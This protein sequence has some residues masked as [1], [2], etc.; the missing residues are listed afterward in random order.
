MGTAIR[1]LAIGCL[2]FVL[3]GCAPS[4]TPPTTSL[5]FP[6][7]TATARPT[8][9]APTPSPTLPPPPPLGLVRLWR[10][11]TQ[12]TVWTLG[13]ADVE[14]DGS[15]EV[16]AAS[17]DHEFYLFSGD[18]TVR[19]TFRAAAPLY[20]AV[21]ADANRDGRPEFFL[22][23]D[24]NRVYALDAD[25]NLLGTYAA[26]GRVTHLAVAD[27]D[28]DRADELIAASWDGV[29]A[30][31]D[32]SATLRS[33]IA[34][35]G[36]PSALITVDLDA[37]GAAELLYGTEEG[38][39]QAL[40]GNGTLVWEH[41]LEGPLRGILY[42][43]RPATGGTLWA[44]SREGLVAAIAVDGAPRWAQRFEGPLVSMAYWPG[45]DGDLLLVGRAGAIL[46]L[47]A[48]RGAVRWELPTDSAV[49]SFSVLDQPDGAVLVAG[50]D[51]GDL[52]L[53]NRWGQLR[54]SLRLPS[55]I[56]GLLPV[57]LDGDGSPEIVARS[58]DFV[59]AF[60]TAPEGDEDEPAPAVPTL[61]RWPEP[62]PL[63][64]LPEGRIS[65][66]AVGDLMLSRSI[67]ERMRGYGPDYPFRAIAPLVQQA[68]IAVGNLECVLSQRGDPLEKGY[69]FRGHPEL[70]AGL[71]T[72]GFDLVSLANN[73]AFDY[74]TE[75][76]QETVAALQRQGIRPVGGGVQAAS[77]VVV[78]VRGIRVAFLARNA[79]GVP[80]PGIAWA[81]SEE[82]I[83]TAVREARQRADLVVVLL[84]AGAEYAPE[85][86]EEQMRL[87]RAAVLAGADLVVG[88]HTHVT[89]P[90]ERFADGFIAYGLGDTVF[91]IDIVDAARDGA[92]LWVVLT[93]EGV[94]QAIWIPTRIVHDVQPRPL[95][96]ADGAPVWR[97]LFAEVSEPLPPPP[98]P[99]PH[100][101]FHV[102][103]DPE[104]ATVKVAQEVAF[105]NS[106]GL[107]LEEIPLQVFPNV[108][109]G[110]FSLDSVEGE[111]GGR[112]FAP[113]YTLNDAWLRL[114]LPYPVRPGDTLTL[115]L[116]YR[117]APPLLDPLAWPP[118]GNLGHT[119]DGRIF[120]LGHW[121]PQ[122]VPFV[123]D[124]GW[125]V[126]EYH[127]VGDP[128]V[129]DLAD[130]SV[131]VTV[132]ADYRVV[133][134][135]TRW[136]ESGVWR[137]ELAAA[138]D[139]ALLIAR[140]YFELS[141]RVDGVEVVSACRQEHASACQGVLEEAKRG[142]ALF[143]ERYGPYPYSTFVVVEGEMNGGMEY[144]AM[145]LVGSPFYEG[146]DGSAQ[147]I[148]PS[149]VV[150]EL[151]H[152]WWYGVVGND[153]VYEPWLDEALARYSELVYYEAI[154]PDAVSW[155]WQNRVDQWAPAGPVDATIYDY[156]DT[157]T[158]V[159]NV[160][161]RAAHWIQDLRDR[162]GDS[163]FFAF[164]QS[165]YRH[166]AW[167]RVTRTDFF[168]LLYQES[169]RPVDDLVRA[170]FLR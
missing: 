138:R 19:W 137:F 23:G 143:R 160:Y 104:A 92:A 95:A 80:Q 15:L 150:H 83:A 27:V 43:P 165:Y 161:G 64:P 10:A 87:A 82:E 55:R 115:T 94:A 73:H 146:Y 154:Y 113:S 25:G 157:R 49:W 3:A 2:W 125:M 62:S 42:A 7:A 119:Q 53:V 47:D 65:L 67:E 51:G 31:L 18:G 58:G 30:I 8:G 48:E 16:W 59:Y 131:W 114:F 140:G 68:D 135:G 117:L 144:G 152:Q 136:A 52:L 91:D 69:T 163:A 41:T 130:Y 85:P 141:D 86:T 66:L 9:P 29:M 133:G 151:A 164:L 99:R 63:P 75:G 4:P 124:K 105:V 101:R 12:D 76:L 142:I 54:G 155:W 32:D 96:A 46:A 11:P 20:A 106:T 109:P 77:P 89:Q 103:L 38:R 159:H 28:G 93:R 110:A 36:T 50:T 60:R 168:S 97:T 145:V 166:Y 21:S 72:A 156:Q 153:Q 167:Q 90:T 33:T 1:W 128:F 78:T 147:A 39:L 17:Y 35:G 74:G 132:P 108:Y 107:F 123:R 127:P 129:A 24:D 134:G 88:H 71:A 139:M 81:G 14:P 102:S 6:P 148:L 162:L 158:Y 26:T 44:I 169:E 56:H 61:A 79:V 37:D 13:T 40:R 112:R 126:W 98:G 70:A 100:Y 22:G 170:Y 84:H 45:A 34:P 57:D 116:S 5:P 149:L 122:I 111:H 118:E 121:Y 120:Q